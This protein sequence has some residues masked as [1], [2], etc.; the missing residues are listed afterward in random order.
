MGIRCSLALALLAAVFLGTAG[1]GGSSGAGSSAA[2]VAGSTATSNASTTPSSSSS[3]AGDAASFCAAARGQMKS[4]T[5]QLAPLIAGTS[6]PE[7]IRHVF[8]TIEAAYR[9]VIAIA[10]TE[11][12][13]D[14]QTVY[15]AIRRLDEASAAAQD[16]PTA[17]SAALLTVADDPKL[18][19]AAK[20]L[21][22]WSDAHCPELAQ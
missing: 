6:S 13:A 7:R 19:A 21:S 22:V 18:Q 11:I 12:R 8:T 15:R 1:C 4:V 3:S 2:P 5:A 16:D 9:R 17:M 14:L 10:P 20:H